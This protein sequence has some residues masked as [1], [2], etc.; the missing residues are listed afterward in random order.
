MGKKYVNP[1]GQPRER[2]QI[3]AFSLVDQFGAKQKDVAKALGVKQSTVS[4]WVKEVRYRKRING[5]ERELDNAQSYIN[6][7]SNELGYLIEYEETSD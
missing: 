3:A 7:L 1:N 5:L 2:C 6:E 4:A